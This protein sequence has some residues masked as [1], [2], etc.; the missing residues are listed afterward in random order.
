MT[1]PR[2][3]T[4]QSHLDRSK[5]T[6]EAVQAESVPS[7]LEVADVIANAFK[8]GNKLLICGNGGSAADSQ[9]IAAEFIGRFQKE[10]RSLPALALTTDT[11]I[12]TA[13]ANDY[14]F[15]RVFAR[16]IEGLAK[17]GDV[18]FGISTSGQS[19]NVIEAIY[20]AKKQEVYVI[21]LTGKDGGKMAPLSD[22]ALIVPSEMTAR[23]QET[24]LCI[25]H[26]ICELV[27]EELGWPLKAKQ[28]IVKLSTLKRKLPLLRKKYQNV[29]FTNGCFDILHFGHV[30]YLESAKRKDRLLIVG[31]NSD[32]SIR[33]LKG[34]NRPIN[35]EEARAIVLA[36]L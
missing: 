14:S 19:Q 4:V 7:I 9:H 21:T 3:A 31:L 10:R 1:D 12:L 20:Q 26:T 36:G 18:L 13:L 24:H 30:S 33:S 5:K 16:Q 34:K 11:S 29:A 23:V 25:A 6:L 22:L 17:S 8:N 32:R 28:K 2:I 15:D 35:K 27:E